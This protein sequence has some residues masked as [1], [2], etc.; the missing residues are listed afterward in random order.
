MHELERT[1]TNLAVFVFFSQ[2]WVFPLLYKPYVKFGKKAFDT[3]QC[4]TK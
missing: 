4:F 2:L 3:A 1:Y